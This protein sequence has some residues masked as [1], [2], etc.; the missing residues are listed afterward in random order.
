M[1]NI[2]VTTED[3]LSIDWDEA[4]S[5]SVEKECHY[6]FSRFYK[7]SDKAKNNKNI[8]HS[9]I[10]KLLGMICSF[11]LDLENYES[12]FEPALILRESRSPSIEDLTENDYEA[13]LMIV[14]LVKDSELK[15]RIADILWVGKRQHLQAKNAVFSYIES[16]WTLFDPIHW[17]SCI[18]R[19][20]R[21]LQIAVILGRKN[22]PFEATVEAIE[23]ALNRINGEDSSFLSARLMELLIE[24]G[25]G[26]SEK[27]S[28]L[29]EKIAIKAE[30]ELE[31]RRA[32][33]YWDIC[34]KWYR[35]KK[36][37]ENQQAKLK[38]Y[39]ETYV[40]EAHIIL[41]RENPSY[42]LASSQILSAIEAHRR[43]KGKNERIE[44]LHRLL[45]TYQE[46]SVDELQSISSEK[47]D[48]SNYIKEAEKL[49]EGKDKEKAIYQ[50]GLIGRVPQKNALRAQVE[51]SSEKY[52][53]KNFF[54]SVSINESGKIIKR[55][56]SMISG[57]QEEVEAAIKVEMYKN[58]QYYHLIHTQGLVEP[59]RRKIIFEHCI[60]LRDVFDLVENN[61]FVP[62]GR[63]IIFAEGLLKGFYGE[64]LVSA[65]LLIP[66]LENSIRHILYE[67]G[68]IASSLDS[69]GVQDEKNLN[70]LLFVPKFEEL[71]SEDIAFDLQGLLV[72]RSGS[73]LRN[74]IAHGLM[75]YENFFSSELTYLWWLTLHLCCIYKTLYLKS[76]EQ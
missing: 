51:K 33:N 64:F 61:P 5:D 1:L 46:Q 28:I 29:S 24:N 27:Y 69:E 13:L 47:I 38:N 11:H 23:E 25:I 8:T 66:Q 17:T 76:L 73:N 53:L 70:S 42:M 31:F 12:P 4:I 58:A 30:E 39:A 34:S 74:K 62:Y 15:S 2:K 57:N 40:K 59:A 16:F 48:I 37:K 55:H 68:E 67:S 75:S 49:V 22:E 41:A 18:E 72:E 54:S 3:V 52:F 32:R 20:E 9:E 63:E 50:L 21:A 45:L 7:A 10:L 71:I 56:P 44:E 36:D 19:I 26:D 6:Y 60:R 35:F 14:E 43:I 65:H